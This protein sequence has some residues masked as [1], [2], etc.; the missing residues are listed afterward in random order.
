MSDS[1]HPLARPVPSGPPRLIES[2][3]QLRQ[4]CERWR[5]EP[6]LGLDT[7]FVRER[8]F[9]PALGLIQVSDGNENFLV[10]PLAIEDLAPLADVLRQP[11]VVKILHS[12]SEDL[13]VLY[14][15]FGELPWPIFDT[16]IAAALV[17]L[18]FGVGYRHLVQELFAVEIPKD[19]TRTDWL[20]RPLT[21][22]QKEYAGLDVAYLPGLHALLDERL[23]RLGRESWTRGEFEQL[24]DANRFLPDPESI[25]LKVRTA[26]SMS[27][28]ELAVLR[29]LCS[30]REKEARRRDLPRNFVIR[31]AALPHLARQ[32]PGSLQA[33][34][35]IRAL[36]P[37]EIRR[38][39]RTL[40]RIVERVGQLPP[41]ELP[42]LPDRPVDL[43]RYRGVIDELREAVAAVAAELDIP[44]E[45]LASRKT[46][47]N[48]VREVL[49]GDEPS[50]AA[51]VNGWRRKVIGDRLLRILAAR[52][53]LVEHG[54]SL[55]RPRTGQTNG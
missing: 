17:G 2:A 42:P 37:N 18:G 47:E 13:E 12:P 45:L 10:D 22:A 7:E 4:A 36:H 39:G 44:A 32:Q 9:Y 14:H 46:V 27:R 21:P 35:T 6:A 3:S 41:E 11:R 30:W 38:H 31:E 20:R 40:V 49:T 5:H 15:R 53:L 52:G 50:H 55:P 24:V 29:A 28:H 34:S 51:A 23:R 33:L 8:T 19:E 43:S 16:Q 26:R 1:P 25:Y 54:G 48:L